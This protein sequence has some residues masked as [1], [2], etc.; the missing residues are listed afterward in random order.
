VKPGEYKIEVKLAARP[1]EF[2]DSKD[3]VLTVIE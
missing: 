3:S 1:F 2:K